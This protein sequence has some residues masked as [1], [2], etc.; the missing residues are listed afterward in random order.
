VFGVFA[1]PNGPWPHLGSVGARTP[2]LTQTWVKL[3]TA[4]LGIMEMEGQVANASSGMRDV[5]SHPPMIQ[6]LQPFQPHLHRT[7]G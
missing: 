2:A 3:K 6:P 1:W 4:V 7:D 5:A